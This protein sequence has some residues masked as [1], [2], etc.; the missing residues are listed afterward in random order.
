MSSD[1][2]WF[3]DWQ[4]KRKIIP[5][6]CS[7]LRNITDFHSISDECSH[8]VVG[9][10]VSVIIMVLLVMW[11]SVVVRDGDGVSLL[12]LICF[13]VSHVFLLLFLVLKLVVIWEGEVHVF[14]AFLVLLC[15][16][17]RSFNCCYN[18]LCPRYWKQCFISWLC[19]FFVNV[20]FCP[21]TDVEFAHIRTYAPR[22]YYEIFYPKLYTRWIIGEK[23]YTYIYVTYH[24]SHCI[25][26]FFYSII[27]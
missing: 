1:V 18:C 24:I 19:S 22:I 6:L 11:F 13:L 23:W 14:R 27:L 12:I 9:T 7:F 20:D 2:S 8:F 16:Y 26:C 4:C 3:C 21:V 10:A 17:F 25:L 5:S 15:C